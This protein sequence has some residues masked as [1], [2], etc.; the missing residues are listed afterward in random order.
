VAE[1]SKARLCDRSL[2]G[3]ESRRGYRCLPLAS[4]FR[5]MSLRRAD[6]SFRGVLPAVL[7][8]M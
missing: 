4:V 6:H 2:A 8:A 5:W 1:R 3:F 7:C